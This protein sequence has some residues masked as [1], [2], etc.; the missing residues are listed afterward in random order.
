LI[1]DARVSDRATLGGTPVAELKA[2]EQVLVLEL[3]TLVTAHR[4]RARIDVP[5]G[6]I[7]LRDT[8][9]GYRWAARASPLAPVKVPE[10]DD[11]ATMPEEVA[12]AAEGELSGH[13]RA[14]RGFSG[15]PNF[16]ALRDLAERLRSQQQRAGTGPG[17]VE[18]RRRRRRCSRRELLA[19]VRRLR[20]EHSWW[21]EALLDTTSDNVPSG[22]Q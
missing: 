15:P 12:E 20:F 19:V 18:D 17:D 13:F 8:T 14:G 10:E 5:A 4:V 9:D 2:G 11:R 21:R 6:W 22:P 1:K 7:T 16:F 3:R